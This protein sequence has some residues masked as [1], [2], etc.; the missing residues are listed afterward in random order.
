MGVS[1]GPA[2]VLTRETEDNA[3]LKQALVKMGIPVVE[4]PCLATEY[5]VTP[6]PEGV[7][8]ATVFTSRRGVTGVLRCTWG[9]H[10][11]QSPRAGLLAAVGE[12]TAR[13]LRRSGFSP[14]LVA[15]PPGGENLGHLLQARLQAGD[16]VAAIQGNL[17]AAG[18]DVVLTSAGVTVQPVVVYR[19]R[20]VEPPALAPSSVKA[21]LAASPSA[22]RRLLSAN[23]WMRCARFVAAGPTTAQELRRLG[24]SRVEIAGVG[25][26]EQL[27]ALF[28]SSSE[29]GTTR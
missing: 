29:E 11:L 16:R 18:L 20:E 12:S 10:W 6:C 23:P 2:V 19:N 21:V 27:S 5:V 26:D 4:A 7:F 14:G 28:R 13:E 25:I 3:P 1:S 9:S 8:Q 17:R 15:D 22:A 24:V